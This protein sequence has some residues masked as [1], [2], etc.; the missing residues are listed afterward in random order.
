MYKFWYLRN[1]FSLDSKAI[2]H[3]R[4][5]ISVQFRASWISLF[6]H[7][8]EDPMQGLMVWFRPVWPSLCVCC[9]KLGVL[10]PSTCHLLS[11]AVT[12]CHLLSPAVTCCH[13]LSPAVTCCHLLSP[14]VTCCHL[15]SPAVT[16]C[17]LLS[18]AVRDL[19]KFSLEQV[20]YLCFFIHWSFQCKV[21]WYGLEQYDLLYVCGV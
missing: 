6:L 17:H 1:F 16:S 21:W 7:S 11:P 19:F 3:C 8:M 14:A 2:A 20:E 18:Y 15:L 12:Y 9:L 13:L 4:S 10:E 5:A